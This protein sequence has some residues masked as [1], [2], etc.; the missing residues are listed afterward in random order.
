MTPICAQ[1]TGLVPSGY[2]V[3]SED[4]EGD[5]NLVN[6][7]FGTF[8]GVDGDGDSVTV[9]SMVARSKEV[10]AIGSL[11]FAR[12]VLDAQKEG[13]DIIPAELRGKVYIILPRTILVHRDGFRC[14]A[15]LI[16]HSE[17]WV[18]LVSWLGTRFNRNVRFVRS[19]ELRSA[20]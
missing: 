5:I 15:F 4:L 19:C 3:E 6:L 1:D 9:D 10:Q 14:A 13:K 12:L 20:A 16:W 8:A 7:D 18:V 11:G 17:R 2:I